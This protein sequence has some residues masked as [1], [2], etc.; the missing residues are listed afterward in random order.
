MDVN[1]W[2][3]IGAIAAAIQSLV[4]F[5]AFLVAMRQIGEATRSRSLDGFIEI[6]RELNEDS[7]RK[8]RKFIYD[9]L[10][11][12]LS[13][14]N[15]ERVERIWVMFDRMGVLVEHGL[16]PADVALSMYFDVVIKTWIKSKNLI[17]NKR[18]ERDSKIYMMY[19]QKLVRRCIRH[20]E[21]TEFKTEKFF[22]YSISE[23]YKV[24]DAQ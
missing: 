1:C 2:I 11:Q 22:E 9:G 24:V 19:F 10:S 21:K 3:I 7:A 12:D 6:S 14:E 8:D 5:V 13:P 15:F 18:L 17:N 4:V 20:W 23:A 16:V